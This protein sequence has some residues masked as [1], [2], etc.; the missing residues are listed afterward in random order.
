[1]LIFFYLI[2]S[3]FLLSRI[4]SFESILVGGKTEESRGEG[5]IKLNISTDCGCGDN[6][7]IV[8]CYSCTDEID[9]RRGRPRNQYDCQGI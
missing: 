4:F 1:M 5:N 7:Q 9:P 8:C 2:A 3:R 6:S